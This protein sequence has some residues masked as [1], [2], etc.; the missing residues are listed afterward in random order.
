MAKQK[1]IPTKQRY[2]I[3]CRKC[4]TKWESEEIN[5]CECGNIKLFADDHRK[6]MSRYF[7]NGVI[8]DS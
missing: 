5:Q 8:C 4:N 2:S 6:L 7:L 3:Q 1:Q